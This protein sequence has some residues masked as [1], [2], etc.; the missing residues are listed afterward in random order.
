MAF[1]GKLLEVK[2]NGNWVE[3]PLKYIKHD[4]Y[5]AAPCQRME[6]K[7]N[8]ATT[9]VLHR[10]TVSHTATKVEF[11]TPPMFTNV[12]VGQITALL[13]SAYISELEKKLEVRYYDT[14]EDDYKT[15]EFYV[16]TVEYTINRVDKVNTL[17]YYDSIRYAFIEY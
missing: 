11:E 10:T 1:N 5:K 14:E 12:D 2:V 15:G 17:V 7:A 6:A 8:R 4:S 16:P 3:F 13:K 9:G